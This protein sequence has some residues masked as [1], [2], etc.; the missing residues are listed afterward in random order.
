MT[1]Y[2]VKKGLQVYGD[3][4]KL[5]VSSEMQQLHDM[6]VVEP[7]KANMLTREE[8]SKALNYLMFLKQKRSGKIKGRGCADGR[9][10]RLYKTKEETSAPT[11]AIESLFLTC[12]IDAKERRT[13]ATTDIPGAFMQTDIDEVIHVRLEGPL[14]TLLAKVNPQLYN[15]YLEQDRKGKPVMYVKLKK[16]LYGTLQ[17]AMLFWKDLTKKLKRWGYVINPYDWCVANKMVHGKQCTVVWH[18]DDLKISH[19]DPTVVQSLLDLLNGEYGKINP[20]VTTHGNQH[21]YLGMTLDYSEDGKVKIIMTDYIEKMLDELPDDMDGE[22]G[23]PASLH[24]FSIRDDPVL[25][26]TPTAELFHHYTA[27]LLFLSRRARPDIQT[28]VSFL[29]KRVKAPDEDDYKKLRRTMQYLRGSMDIL[30]T[31]EADDVRIVKWWVDASYAVHDDLKSHTGGTMS[32]GKGSIYSASKTQRLNTK[33]STEA[34]LV[35]V[36]DVSAQILWTRYFLEG[37]GYDVKDNTLYQDN[38]SAM[39][40][41]K[42]GRA[43][44]SKRTRHINVRY[45]FITD[46][47][48]SREL[49]VAYCP[50]GDMVADYFTKPLQGSAFRKLR[51]IIMNVCKKVVHFGIGHGTTGVC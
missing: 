6:D 11:V 26:D 17:A 5:A 44:S 12:T 34:E 14:A 29:T 37:Q 10:Q 9:K 38:Q 22:A 27:K 32:L 25:L 41:E 47:I 24:L 40:L 16:A 51:D 7:K 8:R 20:L 1:Q 19:V 49:N 42:N 33:S 18:V 31:L 21:D 43:S 48:K 3:A 4:G 30:L 35:G 36:D 39:L 46:R 13:V 50:T 28:A 23:T 2:S 45:F 15:K